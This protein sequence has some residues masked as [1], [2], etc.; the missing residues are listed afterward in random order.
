MSMM[1]IIP[2]VLS[3]A[4]MTNCMKGVSCVSIHV[5]VTQATTEQGYK[6]IGP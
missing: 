1:Y 4:Q 6:V 2:L 5:P 3:V